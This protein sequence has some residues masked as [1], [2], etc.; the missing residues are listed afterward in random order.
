V[1]KFEA[2]PK[3]IEAL[4]PVLAAGRTSLYLRPSTT[5]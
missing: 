4:R 1:R 3:V 2:E 5:P